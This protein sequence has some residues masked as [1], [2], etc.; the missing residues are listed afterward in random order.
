MIHLNNGEN[1]HLGT[2]IGH[3]IRE[4]AYIIEKETGKKA[5]IN[6]G[7]LPYRDRDIMYA[8][9]PIGKNVECTGWRCKINI[10]EGINKYIKDI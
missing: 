5:N 1:I 6:W 4:V 10:Q 7:A 9:A 8:V 3:S 2:G